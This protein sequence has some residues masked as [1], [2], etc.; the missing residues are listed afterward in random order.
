MRAGG[1]LIHPTTTRPPSVPARPARGRRSLLARCAI[2]QSHRS[3][4]PFFQR[5]KVCGE[6]TRPAT[7][8]L[9]DALG[10]GA[11]RRPAG[12]ARFAPVALMHGVTDRRRAAGGR[13]REPM[14]SGARSR[15]PR[16][17]VL[18]GAADRGATGWQPW[19]IQ[20]IAGCAGRLAV[21]VRALDH[22]GRR[23]RAARRVVVA[24]R[25]AQVGGVA[26]RARR[27]GARA[28]SPSDLF[29]FTPN[30]RD[31]AIGAD[32]LPVLSFAAATAAWS[33]PTARLATLACCM[34]ARS[35]GGAARGSPGARAG[36]AIEALPKRECVGVAL[37]GGA[38]PRMR[39]AGQPAHS[40]RHSTRAGRRRLASATPP[41]K[42]IRS[43]ARA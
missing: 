43:L 37:G 32:L 34:R 33:S 13:G 26:I 6:C 39:V 3:N 14:G 22:R 21:R 5:A 36:D 9:L 8:A 2:C 24:G 40:T 16:Y 4:A 1:C 41:A 38:T 18:A 42:R 20:S 31:A 11:A 27:G 19:S 35:P 15:T 23:G 10:I 30:F 25:M 12:R 28:R 7:C 29:A 17:A